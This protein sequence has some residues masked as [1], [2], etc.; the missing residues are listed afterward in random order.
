M[1]QFDS[2]ET[3]K[4][5]NQIG[6]SGSPVTSDLEV[7]SESQVNS[8]NEKGL[9]IRVQVKAPVFTFRNDEGLNEA[10]YRLFPGK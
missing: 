3:I 10:L 6:M 8:A 1:N 4:E 9:V 5:A 7:Y 2:L